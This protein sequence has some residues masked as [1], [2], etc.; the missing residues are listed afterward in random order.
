MT[1]RVRACNKAVAGE[2]SEPVTLETHGR[3]AL[4]AAALFLQT[5]GRVGVSQA[6][7]LFSVQ[8]QTGLLVVPPEPEGGGHECGVGRQRGETTGHPQ[9]EEQNQLADALPS[10]VCAVG[11]LEEFQLDKNEKKISRRVLLRSALMSP[12]RAPTARPGRDRFT[13]ESYTVLG[14]SSRPHIEHLKDQKG[15]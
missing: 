1:F 2:F 9:R 4:H 5:P 11:Q 10:Q 14:K 12:K 6:W 8:L 3:S 15:S 13:A 7:L